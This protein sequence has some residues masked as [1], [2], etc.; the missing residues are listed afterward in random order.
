[1]YFQQLRTRTVKM[2]GVFYAENKDIP[3][4]RPIL[5]FVYKKAKVW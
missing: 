1:M 2:E 5:I 4:V 3:V